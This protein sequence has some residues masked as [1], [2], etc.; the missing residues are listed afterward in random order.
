MARRNFWLMACVLGVGV[1][2]GS[3]GT[4]LLG[5]SVPSIVIRDATTRTAAF[6]PACP[7]FSHA[8]DGAVGPIFCTIDNPLALNYYAKAL[9]PLLALGPNARPGRVQIQLAK[10]MRGG[11]PNGQRL[12]GTYPI[13]C[14][15]FQLAAHRWRWSFL[16]TPPNCPPPPNT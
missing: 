15:V 1:T 4:R 5:A 16:Y 13:Q 10:E 14:Q 7:H 2:L 11:G 9:K 3:A 8:A 6:V 12:T